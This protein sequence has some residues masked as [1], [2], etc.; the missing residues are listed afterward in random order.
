[1]DSLSCEEQPKPPPPKWHGLDPKVKF[2]GNQI[3]D[4]DNGFHDWEHMKIKGRIRFKTVLVLMDSGCTH[5]FISSKLVQVLGLKTIKRSEPYVVHLPD[6]SNQLWTN[7]SC[8]QIFY[9]SQTVLTI[10]GWFSFVALP[11]LNVTS[12][13]TSIKAFL[14][15][16]IIYTQLKRLYM[17]ALCKP[18]FLHGHHRCLLKINWVL[19]S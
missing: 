2:A 12:N 11:N 19:K 9:K 13:P 4:L 3:D 16:F 5:N 1:M 6:G 17:S 10:I 18:W 7:V 14:V 8:F 15:L